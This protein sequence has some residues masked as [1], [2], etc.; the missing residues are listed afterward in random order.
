MASQNLMAF[1]SALFCHPLLFSTAL[2]LLALG[3]NKT[4]HYTVLAFP[5]RACLWIP[6]CKAFSAVW[7]VQDSSLGYGSFSV[8]SQ[9]SRTALR[10][11]SLG[12]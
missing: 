12:G 3:S 2:A 10:V 6:T 5:V 7:F 4:V 9:E 11:V 1:Y 8:A